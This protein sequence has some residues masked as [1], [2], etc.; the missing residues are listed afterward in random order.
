MR[1][2]KKD[3]TGKIAYWKGRLA[4]AQS[5]VE[6]MKCIKKLE[7]FEMRQESIKP[8]PQI[9]VNNMLTGESFLVATFS[10]KGDAAICLDALIN[11][12][13]QSHLVYTIKS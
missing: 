1:D 2:S 4:D 3:Y 11:S 5:T 10:S 8:Q 9:Y 6:R 12:H 13:G 7:Y